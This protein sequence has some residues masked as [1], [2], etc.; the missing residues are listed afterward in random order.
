MRRLA[1][2]DSCRSLVLAGLRTIPLEKS[3]KDIASGRENEVR[4]EAE[5]KIE[6]DCFFE[7]LPNQLNAAFRL[8]HMFGK[9]SGGHSLGLKERT[10]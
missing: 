4:G 6:K 2:S 3:V 8:C 10:W 5:L 9:V 1:F 7:I